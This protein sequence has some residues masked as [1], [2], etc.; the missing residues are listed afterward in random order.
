MNINPAALE[1]DISRD[2]KFPSHVFF[3]HPTP[4]SF[5]S[6]HGDVNPG[7]NLKHDLFLVS[8]FSNHLQNLS[9]SSRL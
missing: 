4:S 1:Y 6:K 3:I 9:S 7:R 5:H 8:L 2:L